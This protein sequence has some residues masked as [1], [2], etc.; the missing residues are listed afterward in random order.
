VPRAS[1]PTATS[2]TAMTSSAAGAASPNA[3]VL[4]FS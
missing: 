3:S 2:D 4:A 1:R